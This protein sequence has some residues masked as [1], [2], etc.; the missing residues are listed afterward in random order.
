M[1]AMMHV[2]NLPELIESENGR[3]MFQMRVTA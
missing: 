3:R 2:S 1:I